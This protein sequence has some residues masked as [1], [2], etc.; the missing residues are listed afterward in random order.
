MRWRLSG[1]ATVVLAL[2]A[3]PPPLSAHT[4]IMLDAR[5]ATPGLRLELIEVTPAT[6]TTSPTYR[7]RADGFKAGVVVGVWTKDFGHSF[8][9]KA[10]GFR[11]DGAGNFIA[12]EPDAGGQQRRL[13]EL[14]LSPGPYA[15][16]ASWEVAVVSEDEK[17][18]AYAKA[19]PRPIS[20]RSGSCSVALELVSRRGDRFLTSSSGFMPN[21]DVTIE[22]REA[23]GVTQKRQRA[24]GDGRLPPDVV[25]HKA[26]ADRR[27]R[28]VVK[29]GACEVSVEYE[30]GDLP[31]DEQ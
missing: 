19:I 7:L 29:G 21:E 20:G 2:L 28:Y 6:E 13:D 30:W 8:H 16:G 4:P 14:V 31:A 10:T 17:L 25:T 11:S 9:Q 18:G 22:V 15:A 27:V 23:A 3:A 5:L 12:V 24:R 26:N 1:L